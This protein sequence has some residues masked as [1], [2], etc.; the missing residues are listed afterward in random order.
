MNNEMSRTVLEK[1]NHKY[2]CWLDQVKGIGRQK[3]FVLLQAAAERNL[4]SGENEGFEAAEP[5]LDLKEAARILFTAPQSQLQ[6]ICAEAFPHGGRGSMAARQLMDAR[7]R[8]PDRILEELCKNKISFSCILEKEFPVRLRT[9]P[10][11]PFGIYYKGSLP[12]DGEPAAGVIGARLASGYGKEQARRFA[13]RLGKEAVSIVSGMARGIDGIA[14]TAALDAGGKSFAV[15]GCGVDI[16]YPK[17]NRDLYD[18]L[19]EHGGIISEYPPGTPPE[20]K[21]FPPRNRII[22]GLSDLVL[23]I[24][25]RKKSGTLIT[26]DM[27]LEQGKEVYALPGR[28]S[29]SLSDGCNRLIRQGAGAATCP[30]DILE[31]FFGTSDDGG[32]HS[33]APGSVKRKPYPVKQAAELME[34]HISLAGT[35]RESEKNRFRKKKRTSLEKAILNTLAGEEELHLERLLEGVNRLLAE[36][37]EETVQI[38]ALIPVLMR[39]QIDKE[40]RE[41]APGY[42]TAVRDPSEW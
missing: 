25:A 9:I 24:E 15:L 34:D 28:V 33:A 8:E 6:F 11:P 7:K 3:C 38:T 27:A 14:Q 22:S 16:C 4:L 29:D 10:D 35:P 2:L 31:Y 21:L 30:E 36:S 19:L 39:L 1:S 12:A 42:Y 26:V 20:S 5:A 32:A 18:R 23:V 40:V 41:E 17:E 37:G 13:W